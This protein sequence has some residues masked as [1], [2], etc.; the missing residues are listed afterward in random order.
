[1]S[2]S[3]EAQPTSET[4]LKA[5]ALAGRAF[6]SA[7]ETWTRMKPLVISAMLANGALAA[8][9]LTVELGLPKNSL[10][11]GVLQ[12]PFQAAI[13]TPLAVA[14]HRLIVKGEVT[15][16][17]IAL[18]RPYHWLFF[19]WL[20]AIAFVE[21]ALMGLVL[22]SFKL[23][24]LVLIVGIFI[25]FIK[26]ALIFPAIAIEAASSNWR[27]TLQT[28][29]RQMDGN[30]W[31]LFRAMLLTLLPLIL[32]VVLITIVFT[33]LGIIVAIGGIGMAIVLI[34]MKVAMSAIVQPAGVIL[35]AAIAS[36]LYLWVIE[37]PVAQAQSAQIATSTVT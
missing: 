16:G 36:W 10:W 15:P 8:I 17:I 21:L 1:M 33:L 18:N 28:S 3:S 14:V 34:A 11:L 13:G 5:T 37:K 7:R 6:E 4:R 9:F 27:A 30:F 23:L 20:C 22:A 2:E 29:W 35:A 12:V 19:A 26:S 31:L 25:F 24:M 32:A